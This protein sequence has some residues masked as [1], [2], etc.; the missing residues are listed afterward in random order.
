LLDE[1]RDAPEAHFTAA[2]AIADAS[3]KP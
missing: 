1:L 2:L 3:Q